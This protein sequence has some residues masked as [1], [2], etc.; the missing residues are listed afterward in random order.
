MILLPRCSLNLKGQTWG[1]CV[2]GGGEDGVW[3]P[4]LDVARAVVAN[5]VMSDA[6]AA[7][8]VAHTR[9][10]RSGYKSRTKRPS[11]NTGHALRLA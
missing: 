9:M 2:D 11:P 7:K 3:D 4:A 6:Q 10:L 8:L 1:G 5:R